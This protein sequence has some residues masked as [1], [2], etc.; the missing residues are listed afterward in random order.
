MH[1]GTKP[2]HPHLTHIDPTYEGIVSSLSP[3]SPANRSIHA[4]E[5]VFDGNFHDIQQ[6]DWIRQGISTTFSKGIGFKCD[7]PQ[8]SCAFQA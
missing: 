4:M 1:T 5:K 8:D 7:C 3:H 2:F 6:R